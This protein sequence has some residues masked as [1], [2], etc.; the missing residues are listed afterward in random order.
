MRPA[1]L[2]VFFDEPTA[3]LDALAEHDLFERYAAEA[4]AGSTRGAVTVL[5]S[6]R[7]STVRAADL[8]VVMEDGAVTAMGP[9][10]ELLL[11]GGLYAELYSLQARAYQQSVPLAGEVA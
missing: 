2:V 11:R 9:H 5:V 4:R 6:H 8:I 10:E 3:S 7:F 1:P